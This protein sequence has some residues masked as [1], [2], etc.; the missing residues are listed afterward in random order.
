MAS[1]DWSKGD[2]VVH[3]TKPEWGAG[4]V[5][6]AESIAHDGKPCQRLTI[7]FARAGT[8]TISTAF[9]DLRPASEMPHLP[10]LQ[11]E[12]PDP[13]AKM[14]LGESVEALMTKLPDKAT[15]PFT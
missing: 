14:A 7:R 13:I 6:E 15:D 1:R 12:D 3:A 9:A 10:E 4:Q 11:H 5:L 8:K 2:S